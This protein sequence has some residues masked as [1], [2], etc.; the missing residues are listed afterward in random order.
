MTA[1]DQAAFLAAGTWHTGRGTVV[2]L[3]E[4][5]P[6]HLVNALVG[7]LAAGEPEGITRPLAQ[8]VVDRGLV[9][10]AEAEVRRREAKWVTN[11][12][13]YELVIDSSGGQK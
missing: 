9:A 1:R 5:H 2:R 8:A 4:M 7:A 3:S 10:A 12:P 11:L 6:A 13:D